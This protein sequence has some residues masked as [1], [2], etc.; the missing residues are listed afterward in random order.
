VATATGRT[1]AKISVTV[2]PVLLKAVDAYV[3]EHVGQDRSKVVDV[4]LVPA[5]LLARVVRSVRRAL[6]DVVLEP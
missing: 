3:A 6:G 5:D 2:D 1:R 4:A